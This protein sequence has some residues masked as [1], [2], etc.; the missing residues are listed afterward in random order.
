MP[1]LRKIFLMWML[2]CLAS[3]SYSQKYG[4]I[5][6]FL[7]VSYYQGD[8]NASRQF[9]HPH[10]SYGGIMRYNISNRWALKATLVGGAISGNDMDFSYRYQNLRGHE[11]RTPIV[12]ISGTIEL[13]FLPYKIGDPKKKFSPYVFAGGTFLIASY[14]PQPFQPAIPFGVGIKF[15]VFPRLGMSLEWGW[16]KTFTDQL[17][18]ITWYDELP[19][20]EISSEHHL[21]KQ[22]GYAQQKDWYSI[23]GLYITYKILT[24]SQDCNNYR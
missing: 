2:I 20:D 5:G 4:E 21:P 8:L 1:T 18:Y 23:F 17:D 19:Y 12:D 14:T 13:N 7:G 11:F 15:N 3:Y 9:Y 6:G 16:R 22:L 10:F 24:S